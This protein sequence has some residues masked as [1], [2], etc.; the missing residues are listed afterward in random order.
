MPKKKI[1]VSTTKRPRRKIF[2]PQVFLIIAIVLIFFI[3]IALHSHTINKKSEQYATQIEQ[4]DEQIKD[5]KNE[6][7]QLDKQEEY[8]QTDEFKE[9]IARTRLGMIKPD[10]KIFKSTE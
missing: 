3:V 5:A 4:L 10:E 2:T 9:E 7:K 8:Q 1:K 6:A